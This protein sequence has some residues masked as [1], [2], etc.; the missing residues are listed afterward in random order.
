MV[1]KSR[2][3]LLCGKQKQKRPIMWYTKAE[4]TLLFAEET[5]YMVNETY[6]AKNDCA[7]A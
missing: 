2:R 6:Y 1:N 7:V 4:E 3:D 5:S